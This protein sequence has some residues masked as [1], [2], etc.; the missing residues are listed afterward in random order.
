MEV[1]SFVFLYFGTKIF[2][3]CSEVSVVQRCPLVEVPLYRD[4][5]FVYD[6]MTLPL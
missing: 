1:S 5:R 4:N 6:Y 2:V 3:R